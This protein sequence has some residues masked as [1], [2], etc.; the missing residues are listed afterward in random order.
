MTAVISDLGLVMSTGTRIKDMIEKK[1]DDILGLQSFWTAA[2]VRYARCFDIGRRHF[3]LNEGIF[4][5]L[6][7]DPVTVHRL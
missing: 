3:D 7:G 2:L 5:G 4:D 6:N 1:T